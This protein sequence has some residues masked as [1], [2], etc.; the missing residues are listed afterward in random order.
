MMRRTP[1]SVVGSVVLVLDLP[2]RTHVLSAALDEVASITGVSCCTL[3]P[4][5]GSLVVTA[6]VPEEERVDYYVSAATSFIGLLSI[7][8]MPLKVMG[9]ARAIARLESGGGELCARVT[10]AERLIARDA[11]GEAFGK[12]GLLHAA[13]FLLNLA[14][15]LTLGVGFGHWE[16]AALNTLGGILIGEAMTGGR[17]TAATGG[18][19]A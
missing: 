14:A 10:E 15:G 1:R 2:L 17:A 12:S 6:F 4:A 13:S 19:A 18:G 9:D 11:E 3:D 5:D 7:A 16:A 8:V